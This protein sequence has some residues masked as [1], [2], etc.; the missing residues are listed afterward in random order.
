[1][2]RGR[3]MMYSRSSLSD[4]KGTEEPRIARTSSSFLALPVTKVTAFGSTRAGADM[5][6]WWPGGMC[7][8]NPLAS[9]GDDRGCGGGEG[10]VGDRG[11]LVPAA[12]MTLCLH[13][14]PTAPGYLCGSAECRA[15]VGD[16]LEKKNVLVPGAQKYS[17]RLRFDHRGVASEIKK[18]KKMMAFVSRKSLPSTSKRN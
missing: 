1:M 16:Q 3:E 12:Q 4:W 11:G 6:W 9:A 17:R 15:V 5:A 13:Y 7:P 8:V 10:R 2:E 18:K 14:G